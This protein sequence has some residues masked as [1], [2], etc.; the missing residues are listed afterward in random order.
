MQEFINHL[1]TLDFNWL[2]SLYQ[3]GQHN[4]HLESFYLLFARYGILFSFASFIYL[5]WNKKIN[6][7]ICS[8]LSTGMAGLVDLLI[9]LFWKRPRPYIAHADTLFPN[10]LGQKLD[11]ASFPS[12][13]TYIAFAIAVSILLYGHKRLGTALL[14][15]ATIIA[16]SRIGAGL[17]YPSDVIGGALLGIASGIVAYIIV[18]K[19]E[20][21]WEVPHNGTKQINEENLTD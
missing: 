5:I 7:L 12:S 4:Y 20:R 6:A 16:L 8:F 18:H 3:L 11:I 17:H 13:H 14:V 1:K 19:Y 15:L 21:Y 2:Y 10:T 9:Y